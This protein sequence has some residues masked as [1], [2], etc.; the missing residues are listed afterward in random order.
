MQT[1]DTYI[2]GPYENFAEKATE[3][4]REMEVSCA[5]AR[6]WERLLRSGLF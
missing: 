2:P 5:A 4:T 3:D 6:P 1:Y